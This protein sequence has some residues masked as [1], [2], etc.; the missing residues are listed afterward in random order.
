MVTIHSPIPEAAKKE[1]IEIHPGKVEH[2][3]PPHKP[4]CPVDCEHDQNSSQHCDKC[5]DEDAWHLPIEYNKNTEFVA[6]KVRNEADRPIQVG[7]HY[8]LSEVNAFLMVESK[9]ASD[10]STWAKISPAERLNTYADHRLNIPAG[11]SVRFEPGDEH[12]VEL[13]KIEAKQ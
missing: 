2:P 11:K 3:K 12:C 4:D 1:D 8:N 6:V 7:S 13:L 9:R 10:G 5:T